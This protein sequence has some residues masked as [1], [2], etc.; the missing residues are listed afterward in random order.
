MII[1][2]SKKSMA[3]FMIILLILSTLLITTSNQVS[4]SN[5]VYYMDSVNGNDMNNGLDTSAAWKTLSK[6]NTT[7]FQPG[8]QILFKAGGMWTGQLHP[9]GSGVHGNPIRIDQYGSG[10]KPLIDGGG[11]VNDVVFLYNQQYWE[12]SNLEITN[13]AATEGP[14]LGVHIVAEDIGQLNHV[15]LEN[16]NIHDISGQKNVRNTGGIL[17]DVQGSVTT[18]WFND[19]LVENCSLENV[20]RTGIATYSKWMNRD[21]FTGGNGP[22]KGW[23]NIVIRN[24][25]LDIIGG[26]GIL[27]R[28]GI[29]ALVEYNV[30]KDANSNRNT[31]NAGMWPFLSDDTLFQYNEAYLTRTILDGQGFDADY[32]SS[33]TMIQYNYSHDNEGGFLL[34]MGPQYGPNPDVT[35]RYNISQNDKTRIVQFVGGVA[36]NF[37]FYN[38]TIYVG[39]GIGSELIKG[40]NLT[41]H[42]LY[43][44]IFYMESGSVGALTGG[45]VF[46]HNSYYPISAVSSDAHKVISDPMLISPGSGSVGR[47]SVDGYML[48]SS[49]PL[50]NAGRTISNNGG[51]DYWG[52]ALYN[53]TPDIGAHEYDG[54]ITPPP[55][56]APSGLLFSDDFE[57]G[58]SVGW[59]KS[60]G[61]WSVVSDGTKVL[62]RTSSGSTES[63][64]TAGVGWDDYTYQATVKLK[65][66][67]GSAGLIFRVT[68]TN[69]F[70]MFRINDNNDNYELY[71]KVNGTMTKVSSGAFT[72]SLNQAY[73]FKVVVTGNNIKGY[74]DEVLQNDWTNATSEL[75]SGYIGFRTHDMAS[76]DNIVVI[77]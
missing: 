76:V 44:N 40:S 75:T 19:I 30:V 41:P 10:P 20:T 62:E 59:T 77:N 29:S 56:P 53:E 12:I 61:T 60:G 58:D 11:I 26:D 33:G 68:D 74:I 51:K 38:N 43:N 16:L 66:S 18:T 28:N 35:A 39:P 37:Q 54:S 6:V 70:Y 57:D 36:S 73:T 48:Q 2:A 49:S 42:Y 45:A 17:Y 7:V 9:L 5:T 67:G 69:N 8:D 31:Y 22:W 3:V 65:T 24:N 25:S 27:I 47:N 50:I 64:A 4:A 34:V 52:N 46:D 72:V 1:E 21:G 32:H 71:K 13:Y 55:P 23:T 14:R 63:Y 15:Y